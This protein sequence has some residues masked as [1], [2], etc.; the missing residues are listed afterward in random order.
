MITPPALRCS[1]NPKLLR[2]ARSI[3]ARGGST[4]RAVLTRLSGT[5]RPGHCSC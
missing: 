1:F 2:K 3:L 4:D 5:R